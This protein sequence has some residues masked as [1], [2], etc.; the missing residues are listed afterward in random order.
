MDAN[1][2]GTPFVVRQAD[3]VASCEVWRRIFMHSNLRIITFRKG[4]IL[5][6]YYVLTGF[7]IMSASSIKLM[8]YKEVPEIAIRDLSY[9]LIVSFYSRI[10]TVT[11]RRPH[12]IAWFSL[13]MNISTR[14]P[15]IRPP[16]SSAI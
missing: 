13:S 11:V 3:G 12:R 6:L 8:T 10:L 1:W 16:V 2:L 15:L 9:T 14:F 5:S 4:T 7:R